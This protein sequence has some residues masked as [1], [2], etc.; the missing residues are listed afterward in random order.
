MSRRGAS[1]AGD[2]GGD[3]SPRER[4]NSTSSAGTSTGAAT[5]ASPQFATLH[6]RVG[7]RYQAA[8]PEILTSAADAGELLYKQQALQ[9]PRPRFSPNRAQELGPEL[10][11]YLKLARSLRD[12]ATF[13]TQEQ[14]ET[15]ALQHLHRFDYNPTDAA[16]SLYARHSIE[17]PTSAGEHQT[18]STSAEETKKWILAFY[19]CMRRTNIDAKVLEQM[20][21]LHEKAQGS[22]ETMPPTEA[23][24]LARLVRRITKWREQCGAAQREKVERARLLQLLH[25]AE[26]MEVVLPE[27]EAIAYRI[28]AFDSALTQL[29]EALERS[30]KRHQNK[31]VGL[32]ELDALFEAV[33]APRLVFP[34]EDSFRATVDEAKDL[35]H[36]IE[37]ML[38]EEKVSLPVMRDVLAKIELVPVNFEQEVDQFQKKMLNA[39]TWLA[40]ARKCMPNRRATRRAGGA[41]PK[42][43]D[44][45]AIRALVEDAPCENSTEMFEMQDLLDCADEWAAKVKEA[46]EGGADV[47]LERL[48]D[49]LD[50]AKDIPVVM[51]EQKYLE[52]EIAA[53]E[54]CTT[55]ALKLA[56]RKSIEEMEELLSKAKEIRERIHPKKQS[57]WKPQVER[58]I[59]ASMDQARKWVNE[60]RDHL[61]FTAFDKMNHRLGDCRRYEQNDLHRH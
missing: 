42:K 16:C 18:K 57:R 39:Q 12:G 28:R 37:K 10:E 6:S 51:D 23:G 47:Q 21:V 52:A 49:L 43:M 11:K 15:L 32:S 27:K 29:K 50:E 17:L 19:R 26:D 54:W 40:K 35:K 55:A 4:S 22:A 2:T 5:T 38:T 33:M 13:D 36:T 1:T 58:D 7:K 34:E 44:L 61:G 14:V 56:S 30:S 48:K 31:K 59:N 46:I 8:I 24:V 20:R 41:D 53:R 60:L 45:K 25:Q 3:Q 9:S